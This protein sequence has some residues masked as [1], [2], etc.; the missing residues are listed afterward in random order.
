MPPRLPRSA[1][2]WIG[3]K[4]NWKPFQ[5]A[6]TLEPKKNLFF[7]IPFHPKDVSRQQIQKLYNECCVEGDDGFN[8]L[9]T[10][11]GSE[12]KIQ[13][14]TVAYSRP[15]NLRDCL[16]QSRLIKTSRVNIV[17]RIKK[18]REQRE[19]EVDKESWRRQE[20]KGQLTG[21]WQSH[22]N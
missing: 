14:L 22:H 13:T 6:E 9:T 5:C 4:Q 21:N 17:A 20:N 16:V 10:K 2:G 11:S 3:E 1:R 8:C 18:L 7:H 19:I 12:M 15:K